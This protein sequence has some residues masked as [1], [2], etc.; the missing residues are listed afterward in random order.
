MEYLVSDVAAVIRHFG[1]D[2]A[3][4]SD[5]LNNNWDWNDRDT[6]IV[7]APDANH[8][9]QQDAAGLVTPTLKW[10]LLSRQ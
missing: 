1:E 7:S 8:F 9:V 10:W 3:L 5:G 6:T 4:H 2:K